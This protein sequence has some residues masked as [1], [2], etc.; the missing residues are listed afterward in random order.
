MWSNFLKTNYIVAMGLVVALIL[1]IML[2]TNET[3]TSTIAG[4][5]MGY[6]SKDKF[7]NQKDSRK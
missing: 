2:G 6:L 4:G 7:D 3:I 1:N 5:L